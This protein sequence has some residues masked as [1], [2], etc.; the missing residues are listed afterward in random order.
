MTEPDVPRA[1]PAPVGPRTPPAPA[2]S[3]SG[4]GTATAG[5][6][7]AATATAEATTTVASE[8]SD[9]SCRPG[10]PAD[11][12]AAD[13]TA[14]PVDNPAL[15]T[16]ALTRPG[17]QR[18]TT[19]ERF[20]TRSERRPAPRRTD[21]R[22]HPS[23]PVHPTAG[24]ARNSGL[25]VHFTRDPVHRVDFARPATGGAAAPQG[26]GVVSVRC[27]CRSVRRACRP[28]CRPGRG[29]LA[30]PGRQAWR[31]PGRHGH[32]RETRFPVPSA[33]RLAG[34]KT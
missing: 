2:P 13:R 27:E 34:R 8:G 18:R 12:G 19:G 24:V 14:R 9:G 28:Q 20:T 21:P 16:T 4:T 29:G 3:I 32:N 15:W 10:W 7:R 22:S 26:V 33:E 1:A 23:A 31:S 30:R 5:A 6:R 25:P 17:E 11:A